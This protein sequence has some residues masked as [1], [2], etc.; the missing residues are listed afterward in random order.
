MDPAYPADRLAFMLDDAQAPVLITSPSFAQR[1]PT[2]KRE[3][4]N[5]NAPQIAT[6]PDDLPLFEKAPGDLAYVIYTSGSTGR[7]KGV[8][9]THG[10]L[11]N[12]VSWHQEA[13]SVTSA[14]RAS[15]LAGLGF[16]AAVWELWPYLA[17]G[18]SIHLADEDVSETGSWQSGLRLASSR[19][20]SPNA[21]SPLNGYPRAR[22]VFC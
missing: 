14:D 6:E 22:Y 17:T 11:T 20:R 3:I 19:L 16:D 10:S 12:L 8:E 18:A 21:C 2:A 13:F 15:H 1:M 5:I 7:P 4:V 9:I